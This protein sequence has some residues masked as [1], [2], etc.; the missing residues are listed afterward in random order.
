MSQ[1]RERVAEL[2]QRVEELEATVQGLTEELVEKTERIRV[3]EE[4]VDAEGADATGDDAEEES[5]ASVVEPDG[6]G[7]AEATKAPEGDASKRD[8]HDGEDAE[9]TDDIIVA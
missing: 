4:A 6:E 8:D 3:L 7:G 1:P 5:E 9:A 2:E